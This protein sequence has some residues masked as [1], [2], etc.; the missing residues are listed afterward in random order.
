M[1]IRYHE[2]EPAEIIEKTDLETRPTLGLLAIG[3]IKIIL[4]LKK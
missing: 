1:E 4:C 2:Q 3:H